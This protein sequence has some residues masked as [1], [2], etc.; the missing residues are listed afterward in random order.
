MLSAT[1]LRIC[2]LIF[3][4]YITCEVCRFSLA[5]WRALVQQRTSIALT[6]SCKSYNCY[7]TA[8]TYIYVCM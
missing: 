2:C 1:S 4:A 3:C 5:M 7:A 6:K 8:A